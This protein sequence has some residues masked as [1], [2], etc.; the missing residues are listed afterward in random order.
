MGSV[1]RKFFQC[2]FGHHVQTGAIINEYFG[3]DVVH[4]FD[5]HMQSPVMSSPLGRDFLFSEGEVV[6]GCDVIDES[7]KAFYGDVLG[8]MS[9]IQ[10]FY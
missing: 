2:A 5:S 8:Y 3:H 4:A 1:K 10:D 6:V 9:F 7:P